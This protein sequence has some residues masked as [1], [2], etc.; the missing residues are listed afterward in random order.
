MAYGT[1]TAGGNYWFVY[2]NAL[3]MMLNT[4]DLS[5]AEHKAFMEEAIAANPNVDWKIVSFHQSIYTV[6]SH[7][8]NDGTSRREEL[9]PVFDELDI[10]VVLMG[11]DHVYCRTY[12]MDGL[13]PMTDASIYDDEKYSSI[14]DPDGI[15]YVTANSG[16]GS[17]HYGIKTDVQFPYSAVQ[18]QERNRRF[19]ER[20]CP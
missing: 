10:D 19:S 8:N 2:N 12:M 11:H 7:Y 4:N 6:A 14:T 5:T 15:L 13:T 18:N 17:K 20:I 1:T 3:F 16:S 9:V